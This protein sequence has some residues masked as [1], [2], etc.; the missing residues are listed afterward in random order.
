MKDYDLFSRRFKADPFPT[1]ARLRA[2]DPVYCHV[3][4]NGLRIWYISRYEDV[5]TVLNDG[6][7][8]V[9][10]IHN[11]ASAAEVQDKAPTSNILQLINQNMLFAD[12]PDHTRLRALVGQAFTPR[13]VEALVPRIEQVAEELLAELAPAGQMELIDDYAFPLPLTVI[14][15]LLGVPLADSEQVRDWSRAIIAPGSHGI[16]Y[17]ERKR[18]IRAF[19]DYI[20]ELAEQRRRQPAED[21][22]TALVQADAGGDQLTQQELGSMV[23]LL[24]VTGHETVVNLIGNGAYVLLGQPEARQ[25]LVADSVAAELIVE[26]LLRFDGPVETSTTRWAREDLLFKGQQI[27]RGDLVRVVL[28]SANR[29]EAQFDEPD[30]FCPLRQPNPHLAFGRGI[31][32]CLGAPLARHEGR[33]AL[34]ALFGRWP[35]IELAVPVEELVWRSGVL[36]RGLKTLPL[37]W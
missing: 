32:Y 24:L 15:D 27:R 20:F 25:Q 4:P 7:R 29:D 8:F 30:Q 35:A 5:V 2:E 22:L 34:R 14:M 13:R 36:F 1:F 9:K 23:V 6:E 37:R 16:S 28:S 12:P 21:L 26:E 17:G 11:A 19:V 18:K 10:N 3:A 31:H 33:I